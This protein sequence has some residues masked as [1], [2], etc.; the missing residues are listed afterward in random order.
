MDN[1]VNSV[2]HF[3]LKSLEMKQRNDHFTSTLLDKESVVVSSDIQISLSH[4]F[5]FSLY[6]YYVP[7]YTI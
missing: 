4:W 7:V 3:D 2:A 6:N 1:S 5:S